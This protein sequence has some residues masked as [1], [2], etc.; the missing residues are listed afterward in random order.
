MTICKD[1][2]GTTSVRTTYNEAWESYVILG[3]EN[4]FDFKAPNKQAE[5]FCTKKKSHFNNKT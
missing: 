5:R 4:N 2:F 3:K 1:T